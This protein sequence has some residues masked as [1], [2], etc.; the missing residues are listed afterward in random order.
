MTRHAWCWFSTVIL[1]AAWSLSAHAA[2]RAGTGDAQDHKDEGD[3]S[4][5]TFSVV[6][7]TGD[8]IGGLRLGGVG[9]LH[10]VALNN[11]GQIVF[12][13]HS[14]DA[15]HGCMASGFSDDSIF[16]TDSVVAK[17]GDVIAGKT[18]SGL[19]A[20]PAINEQGEIA[21][22]AT[23]RPGI[24][25]PTY[26]LSCGAYG[27]L[28]R[29]A[30]IVE[31]GNRPGGYQLT[32]NMSRPALNDHGAIVFAGI[33]GEPP[34]PFPP[35]LTGI[36]TPN[37]LVAK[38]GDVI[39]G[40]TLTRFLSPPVLN[41][42]GEIVFA[43]AFA[44]NGVGIFTPHSILVKT[45]DAISGK[46]L[47]VISGDTPMLNDHGD[48]AFLAQF[49]S[50]IGIGIFTQKA[51]LV[52]IGDTIAGKQLN[53]LSSPSAFNN[54]GEIIFTA[55]FATSASPFASGIF[56]QDRLVVKT[57]DVIGGKTVTGLQPAVLNDRGVIAFAADFS[58][59]TQALIRAQPSD[60]EQIED[61]Q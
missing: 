47:M 1:L 27:I 13:W 46:A 4:G 15:P 20:H 49:S 36:F 7:K 23:F 3:G 19:D 54:H 59:G 60:G 55:G 57:G 26:L 34:L 58:D 14:P 53:S 37:A 31:T 30:V 32:F 25:L 6:A 45:G 38:V 39:A 28:T 10:P 21:I 42:K 33:Y 22:Y 40:K 44:P 61:E 16:T 5:Y 48:I 41:N 35:T 8:V 11:H 9:G 18:I 12:A 29:D 17:P 52:K 24:F 43:S 56:T 50:G 51:L 2:S